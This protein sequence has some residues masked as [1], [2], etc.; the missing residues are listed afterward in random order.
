M[1]SSNLSARLVVVQ[2]HEDEGEGAGVSRMVLLLLPGI[3]EAGSEPVTVLHVVSTVAPQP[4][5][6]QV[7]RSLPSAAATCRQLPIPA[8]PGHGVQDTG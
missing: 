3:H 7:P 1:T 4:V 2:V 8:C 5:G 6:G